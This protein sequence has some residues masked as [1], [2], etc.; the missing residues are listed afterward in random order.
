MKASF[1]YG[2][3]D[4]YYMETVIQQAIEEVR[5]EGETSK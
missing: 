5:E 2:I 4:M 3:N 1:T